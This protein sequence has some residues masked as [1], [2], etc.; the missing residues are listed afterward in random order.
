MNMPPLDTQLLEKLTRMRIE[1]DGAALTFSA[2]LAREN[3]WS[4]AYA[5][6]VVREYARFLYLA[7]KAG[8]GVTPSDEVD[9]AWHLHLAYTRHYWGVLCDEILGAPLHHGP[10]AGGAV[11]GQRYRAQYRNTLASYRA[12]FGEDAPSDIWP[13][14]AHRFGARFT[15]VESGRNVVIPKSLGYA[16]IAA[17]FLASCVTLGA[18]TTTSNLFII[19]VLVAGVMLLVKGLNYLTGPPDKKN[20]DGSGCGGG[21]SSGNDGDSGCGGGCGD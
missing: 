6:R 16:A 20:K 17:P 19:L 2:R 10:T 5:Q 3:G 4:V 15:R 11:E 12:H 18:S 21:C 9:Q 13:G 7:A 1:P 8:H 14:E